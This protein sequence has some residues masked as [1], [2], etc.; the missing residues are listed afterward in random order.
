[1]ED[2]LYPSKIE[3]RPGSHANE[4][5][6]VVEPF[7][8][9][10]GTTIGNALRRALLS[11]LPGAAITAVRIKGVQHEFSAIP[12]VKEDVLELILN[13]KQVRI[14]SFSEEPVKLTLSVDGERDV[15]AGDFSKDAQV[16][17][18]NPDLHL[19]TITDKKGSLEMEVTVERGRGWRPTEERDKEKME[20][21]T[22]AVDALF[23]PVRTVGFQVENTRV[24]DITNYDK[25][26]MTIETDGT[27][28][29]KDAVLEANKILLRHFSLLNGL[30]GAGDGST[31]IVADDTMMAQA[32]ELEEAP[33]EETA[34]VEEAG[35]EAP[36]KKA[37]KKS[38]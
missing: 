19:C 37:K 18:A 9:G 11:S 6:L 24:G 14:S 27:I 20:L 35:E 30:E 21:G 38:S 26:M 22:I 23:S 31:D 28:T 36:K 10:Y 17:I 5:M 29:P 32:P 25:L 15:T 4:A 7:T 8:Q 16:E 13:L 34:E 2:I 3:L 12:D 33:A 1:M